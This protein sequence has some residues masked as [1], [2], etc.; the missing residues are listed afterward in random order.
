MQVRAAQEADYP[1]VAALWNHFIRHTLQTFTTEEKTVD[2]L[3][4]LLRIFVA[5]D[6]G[7]LGFAC[8]FPFRSGPGYARSIEHSVYVAPEAQGRGAGNAL[9]EVLEQDAASY[10]YHTLIAGISGANPGGV[11]FHE[12][13]GFAHVG[14]LPEVGFKEG[15]YLDLVLMQKILT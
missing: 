12:K 14:R 1:A 2:G 7:V 3:A 13:R 11:A 8:Y 4:R 5:E 6:S 9:M 15:R 10:G